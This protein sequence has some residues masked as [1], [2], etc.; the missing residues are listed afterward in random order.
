MKRTLFQ[1]GL[2]VA[3]FLFSCK[4]DNK[5][6]LCTA[7]GHAPQ[8]MFNFIDKTTSQDLFFSDNPKYTKDQLK[9]Y[10]FVPL[11]NN[12]TQKDTLPV[13]V[14][15]S[16]KYFAT[17]IPSFTDT[18]YMQIADL[19]IDTLIIKSKRIVSTACYVL[20]YPD[21]VLFDHQLYIADAN[22][23]LTLEK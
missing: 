17:P 3:L 9:V 7:I 1:I 8:L 20:P 21:S 2:V 14:Y 11:E 19:S 15:S 16:S 18:F 6:I 4:K 12:V 5:E 23:I 13:T 22:H 10:I